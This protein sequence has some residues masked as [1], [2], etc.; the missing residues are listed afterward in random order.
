MTILSIIKL[1][2]FKKGVEER[3]IDS[4]LHLNSNT[5]DMILGTN[6]T[7][8]SSNDID[9][10]VITE[11]INSHIFVHNIIKIKG[12]LF[13]IST[14]CKSNLWNIRKIYTDK[15]KEFLAVVECWGE[16]ICDTLPI[17]PKHPFHSIEQ[18]FANV[19]LADEDKEINED[20]FT[21]FEHSKL[22]NNQPEYVMLPAKN[23]VGYID[24]ELALGKFYNLFN[25]L[26]DMSEYKS[27]GNSN[28]Q[29][30]REIDS[31]YNNR[32]PFEEK[33]II[34]NPTLPKIIDKL[35][36][37]YYT[38]LYKQLNTKITLTHYP[39]KNLN[40]PALLKYCDLYLPSDCVIEVEKDLI[41]KFEVQDPY[42]R[43]IMNNFRGNYHYSVDYPLT[44]NDD[45]PI[46]YYR[47]LSDLL[48]IIRYKTGVDS[49]N[50]PYI[51]ITK[52]YDL[53]IEIN[54]EDR[55]GNKTYNLW[56]L[57][58]LQ[59]CDPL[60]YLLSFNKN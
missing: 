20:L 38:K 33:L 58:Q 1:E 11:E 57:T 39:W 25:I 42:Y 21:I 18:F 50:F 8:F 31:Y 10:Y 4:T 46:Y 34:N 60:Q 22:N 40:I 37:Y 52:N 53:S 59:I 26:N 36:I 55:F 27:V 16:L 45:Y 32:L 29:I 6:M 13:P 5:S 44:I 14:K 15:I 47:V 2:D 17:F 48:G 41:C 19:C 3:N 43:S 30:C 23:N 49:F 7:I 24:H 51:K 9:H 54:L 35:G 28:A 56:D 12:E